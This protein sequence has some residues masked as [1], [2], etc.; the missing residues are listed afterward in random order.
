MLSGIL[1]ADATLAVR[2]D[3]AEESWRIVDPVL[4]SWRAG[5]VPLDEYPAGV[6]RS[7][8]LAGAPLIVRDAGRR[9]EGAQGRAA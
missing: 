8:P 5:E 3:A 4:A 7:R 2:G 6:A 9:C 1:D